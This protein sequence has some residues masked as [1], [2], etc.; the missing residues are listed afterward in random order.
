V[1]FT[2]LEEK[3]TLYLATPR[4]VALANARDT[5]LIAV[6]FGLV[7]VC[8]ASLIAWRIGESLSRPVVIMSRTMRRMAEG[9]LEVV[10]P[11][12]HPSTELGDMAEALESFPR[13][14][15]RAA[16]SGKRPARGGEDRR[17]TA[18]SSWRS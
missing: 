15:A 5:L 13:Q 10:A 18:A 14:R 1:T 11:R 7:A 17:R 12:A 6:I 9:D 8:M 2:D 4:A 16:R 3:W